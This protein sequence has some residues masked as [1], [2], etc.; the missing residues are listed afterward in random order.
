MKKIKTTISVFTLALL[1]FPFLQSCLGDSDASP[2]LAVGTIQ[3]IDGNDYYFL[4]D[5]NKKMLPGDTTAIHNYNVEEG[6]RVIVHFYLL[7]EKIN[8]YDYNAEV[9]RIENIL[10]KDVIALTEENIE[11]IGDDRINLTY[12][13]FAG[14]CL[15][16]E[17]KYQGSRNPSNKHFINLVQNET[18]DAEGDE[19]GYL[20][21]EFRHNAYE[22]PAIDVIDGIIAFNMPFTSIAAAKGVKIRVNTLYEGVR[23]YKI[24]F[25]SGYNASFRH[26]APQAIFM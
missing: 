25:T 16:I 7:D 18:P 5:N 15:N 8:G 14:G 13:W 20:T 10:T 21:L 17:F 6:K 9:L 11:E 19:D 22:D 26:Y 12:M 24:D 1:L 2:A 4:L 3:V 23:H